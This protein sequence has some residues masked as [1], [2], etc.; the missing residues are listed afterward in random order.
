MGQ[1]A[2]TKV[3]I[4]HVKSRS[5][6]PWTLGHV[7]WGQQSMAVAAAAVSVQRCMPR[8]LVAGGTALLHLLHCERERV[9]AGKQKTDGD[10]VQLS[11]AVVVQL[12]I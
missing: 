6:D 10:I 2:K 12:S 3:P 11:S 8:K 5:L 7:S 1:G 9:H 4:S